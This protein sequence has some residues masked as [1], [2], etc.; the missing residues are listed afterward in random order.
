MVI[1]MMLNLLNRLKSL[2]MEWNI[3]GCMDKGLQS[4]YR[5]MIVL[6]A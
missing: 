4:Q 1:F 6:M 2:C 5:L 3:C